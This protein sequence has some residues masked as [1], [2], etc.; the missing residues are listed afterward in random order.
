MLNP[1]PDLDDGSGVVTFTKP[2]LD[3]SFN[4]VHL[5]FNR[6]TYEVDN[7]D[8]NNWLVNQTEVAKLQTYRPSISVVVN[9]ES[10][11]QHE[12]LLQLEIDFSNLYFIHAPIFAHGR[13]PLSIAKRKGV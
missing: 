12:A 3:S 10:A 9:Y 1:W 5:S 2:Q 7:T 11:P 6:Q 4:Q 8:P 13:M